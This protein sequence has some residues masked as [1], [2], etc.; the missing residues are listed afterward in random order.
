MY[1]FNTKFD[2]D[3][4]KSKSNL[5]KH[6]VSFEDARE[7]WAIQKVYE[8]KARSVYEERWMRIGE[9]RGKCYSCIYVIREE[10]VRIVSCRR[11]RAREEMKY[12]EEIQK[13]D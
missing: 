11:S 12:R 8:I 3:L 10:A 13:K 2:Y 5:E 9:M 6:G 4:L 1:N 7:L